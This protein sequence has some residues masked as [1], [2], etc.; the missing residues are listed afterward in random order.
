M[1]LLAMIVR[2]MLPHACIYLEKP[3]V[4]SSIWNHVLCQHFDLDALVFHRSF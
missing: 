1:Y 2:E 3:N 4:N